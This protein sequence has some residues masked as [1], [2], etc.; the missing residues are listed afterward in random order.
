MDGTELIRWLHRLRVWLD[1]SRR[2]V[3]FDTVRSHEAPLGDAYLTFDAASNS[4]A[5]SF[6]E[7]RAY[8]CGTP[9]SLSAEG[10]DRLVRLFE[11]RG[12][13]RFFV[14]LSPGHDA[15]T[16][17]DRLVRCRDSPRWLGHDTR[18]W[19]LVISQSARWSAI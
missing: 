3:P 14:W 12:I 18:H 15:S 7:N 1:R 4:P 19:S 17:H 9:D 10:P 6:N 2:S 5:A 16:A 13:K 11:D 8:L